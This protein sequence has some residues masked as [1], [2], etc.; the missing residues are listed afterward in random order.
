M[1]NSLSM[2]EKKYSEDGLV[3][4]HL[5]VGKGLPELDKQVSVTLALISGFPCSE[6]T[7][8][9]GGTARDMGTN[10]DTKIK[11]ETEHLK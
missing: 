9:A 10:N 6:Q 8:M 5:Y 11:T 3:F 4:D 1:K 2:G 7:G